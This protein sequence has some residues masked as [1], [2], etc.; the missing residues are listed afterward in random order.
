MQLSRSSLLEIRLATR[1][2]AIHIGTK[3]PIL[4][5]RF[6]GRSRA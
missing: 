3:W 4:N 5:V 6:D 2:R 1:G